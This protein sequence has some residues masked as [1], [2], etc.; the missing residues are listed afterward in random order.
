[1]TSLLLVDNSDQE[2]GYMLSKT[3]QPMSVPKLKN[4]LFHWFI[5]ISQCNVMITSGY[6]PTGTSR[7]AV[8]G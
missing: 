6:C 2:Q 1:M 4:V 5:F 3:E 8:I 7:S